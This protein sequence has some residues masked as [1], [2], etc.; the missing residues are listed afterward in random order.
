M[1]YDQV[2]CLENPTD[3]APPLYQPLRLWNSR[4]VKTRSEEKVPVSIKKS[5]QVPIKVVSIR[6][7]YMNISGGERRL[8]IAGKIFNRNS[9][10]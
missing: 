7:G 5:V 1:R 10:L 3:I 8:V 2:L 6:G 9:C 4:P